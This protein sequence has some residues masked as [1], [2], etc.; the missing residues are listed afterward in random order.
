MKKLVQLSFLIA[1]MVSATPAFAAT[2]WMDI[3]AL[4]GTPDMLEDPAYSLLPGESFSV[5]IYIDGLLPVDSMGFLL[6]FDSDQLAASNAF[7]DTPWTFFSPIADIQAGL[8][9]FAGSRAFGDSAEGDDVFLAHVDF[10]CILA[11][12]STLQLAPSAPPDTFLPAGNDITYTFAQISQVPLPSA[13]FLL[14][15]G[16]LALFGLRRRVAK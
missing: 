13:I 14:A 3:Y 1:L 6:N 12:V 2:T 4:G 15:P 9:T 16:L 8:V 5:D 7:V 11:G 10:S